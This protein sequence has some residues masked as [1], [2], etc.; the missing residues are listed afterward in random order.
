MV[1]GQ[2]AIARPQA[3]FMQAA[4]GSFRP[5][6]GLAGNFVSGEP[7]IGDVVSAGFSGSYGLVKTET[8]ITLLDSQGQTLDSWNEPPGPALFAFTKER[9]PALVYVFASNSLL[10]W[11][12]LQL[13]TVPLEIQDSVVSMSAPD[14]EHAALIVQRDDGLWQMQILLATGQVE[15]QTALPDMTVPVFQLATGDLVSKDDRGLVIHQADNQLVHIPAQL[16][17]SFWLQQMGA[18]W[19]QLRDIAN[20]IDFAVRIEKGSEQFYELP[21]VQ[22]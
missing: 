16:P 10:R 14:S 17:D 2:P 4:D 7:V 5:V 6:F 9:K 19:L 21:G 11:S 8:S 12:G 1:W 3:G 13:A 22:P 18:G 20:G 15:S